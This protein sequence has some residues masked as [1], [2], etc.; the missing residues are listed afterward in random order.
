[1]FCPPWAL[2]AESLLVSADKVPRGQNVLH[3]LLSLYYIITLLEKFPNFNSKHDSINNENSKTIQRT[4]LVKVNLG[5]SQGNAGA[6]GV[7][8]TYIHTYI[9]ANYSLYVKFILYEQF[10]YMTVRRNVSRAAIPP[11]IAFNMYPLCVYA[12]ACMCKCICDWICTCERSL[13][14]CISDSSKHHCKCIFLCIATVISCIH[15]QNN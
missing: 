3:E 2:S 13:Y 1:M 15:S 12:H 7:C 9:A 5:L 6:G 4:V 14:M 8:H 11:W 10:F